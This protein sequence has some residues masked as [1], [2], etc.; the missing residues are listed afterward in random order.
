MK[1]VILSLSLIGFLSSCAVLKKNESYIAP[2]VTFAATQVLDRAVSEEDLE[3]KKEIM[4]KVAD[5][6]EKFEFES[7]P[8]ADEVY[9]YVRGKL[10]SGAHWDN[11]TQR[12]VD[13]YSDRTMNIKDDD[14]KTVKD[15]LSRISAGLR[16][17]VETYT[18]FSK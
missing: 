2:V 15:T 1:K 3:K 18:E 16:M 10:P 5:A 6:V 11:L 14:V 13:F 17:A 4:V 9:S 12:I 8:G 7:K